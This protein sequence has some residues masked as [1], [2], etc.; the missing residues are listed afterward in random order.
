MPFA[1][2]KDI[3][4]YYEERGNGP[5]VIFVHGLGSSHKDWFAQARA[6][7]HSFRVI[8]LDLRGHGASEKPDGRYS[9]PLMADDI[10]RLMDHLNIPAAHIV[11]LSMGGMITLQLALDHPSRV[12]TLT[13]I[14]CDPDYRLTSLRRWFTYLSRILLLKILGPEGVARML[15]P[16]LLPDPD[17]ANLRRT[18]IKRYSQND[19]DALLA[20]IHAIAGWSILDDLGEITQPTLI[21][22]SVNDYTDVEKKEPFVD[23]MPDARLAVLPYSHHAVPVERPRLFN[24]QL[25][26][27]LAEYSFGEAGRAM[28][29]LHTDA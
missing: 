20:S 22:A 27:F 11:G 13:V 1:R 14:N 26:A 16:R 23:R 19:P 2:L 17:Q 15:A 4:L 24:M 18:F 5:P 3:S 9:I 10:A 8:T 29:Q 12:K 25:R 21:V 28:Q 7:A 6:F